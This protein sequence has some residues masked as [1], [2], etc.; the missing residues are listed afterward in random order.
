M[1]KKKPFWETNLN[2]I[3]MYRESS[4]DGMSKELEVRRAKDKELRDQEKINKKY[5]EDYER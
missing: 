2:P 4:F 5:L 3:T 1:S